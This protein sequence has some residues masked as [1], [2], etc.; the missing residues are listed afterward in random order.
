MT[1]KEQAELDSTL[2]EREDDVRSRIP[3]DEVEQTDIYGEVLRPRKSAVHTLIE[4]TDSDE[5]GN[6]LER[7]KKC[8]DELAEIEQ[9]KS[10]LLK[11]ISIANGPNKTGAY[12]DMNPILGSSNE[13]KDNQKRREVKYNIF[14]N[15]EERSG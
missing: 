1:S 4:S 14:S 9:K 12:A 5:L 11:G 15:P 2:G 10:S 3:L 7:Q 6:I 13:Q 8:Q